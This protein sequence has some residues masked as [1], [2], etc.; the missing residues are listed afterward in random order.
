MDQGQR[1]TRWTR[2]DRRRGRGWSGLALTLAML[3][4]LGLGT[5]TI[6]ATTA[7]TLARAVSPAE[8]HAQVIAQGVAT[9]PRV[10]VGWRVVGME[11]QPLADAPIAERSL[12]FVLADDGAVLVEDHATGT[13]TLLRSFET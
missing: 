13:R 3:A 7:Q 1:R 5:V 4:G 6:S 12:G 10:E 11:A 2:F 8:G 9:M